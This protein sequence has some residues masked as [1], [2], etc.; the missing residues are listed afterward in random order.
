MGR[1]VSADYS[2]SLIP[3]DVVSDP[4]PND[5]DDVE[6]IPAMISAGIDASARF[7]HSDADIWRLAERLHWAITSLDPFP[8][9]L[10]WAELSAREREFY[11]CCINRLFEDRELV[12]RV[13]Q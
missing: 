11:R 13:T 3:E 4:K 10:E 7:S 12:S 6:I 1:G 2:K 9:D 8:D 5:C